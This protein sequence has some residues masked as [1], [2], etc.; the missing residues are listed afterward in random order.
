[1]AQCGAGLRLRWLD[2]GS[3]QVD[4]GSLQVVD[5]S[6]VGFGSG[7]SGGRRAS[8]QRLKRVGVVLASCGGS[9]IKTGGEGWK[10][11][12]ARQGGRAAKISALG[13]ISAKR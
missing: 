10:G 8:A 6:G 11:S 13:V 3:L 7:G 9:G 12:E 2:Y 5:G 1:V 4:Y